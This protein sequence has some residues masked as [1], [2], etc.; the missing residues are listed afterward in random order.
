MSSS[1]TSS[2]FLPDLRK[3]GIKLPEKS[4]HRNLSVPEY[5]RLF[6]SSRDI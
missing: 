1:W 4:I 5:V 6:L 2:V 3:Q